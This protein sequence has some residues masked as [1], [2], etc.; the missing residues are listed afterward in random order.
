MMMRVSMRTAPRTSSEVARELRYRLLAAFD[1]AG[2]K[3]GLPTASGSGGVE[4]GLPTAR[5][6]DE[7]EAG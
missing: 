1:Q 6:S 5:E 7:V 3:V 2:V 4:A